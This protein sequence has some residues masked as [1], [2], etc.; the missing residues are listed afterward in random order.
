MFRFNDLAKHIKNHN[1]PKVVSIEEDATRRVDYDSETD[2]C[3]GFVFPVDDRGL[4]LD[5][6][7]LATSFSVIETMFNSATI[8]K[9]AYN[10]MA[11]PLCVVNVPPFCL[12]CFGTD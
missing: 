2:R 9:Y 12:A 11:Q 7:F 4:P 3:V 1:V 10:Y 8:A 6:S 5:D